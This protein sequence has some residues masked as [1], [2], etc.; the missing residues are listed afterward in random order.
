MTMLAF[1]EYAPDVSPFGEEES[2]V[3]QNVFARKDGYG[4]VMSPSVYSA[5]L[6]SACR[7]YF[8]ARNADA[9]ITVFAAT[10]TK[11]YKLNNTDFTWTDVSKG[12]GSYSGVPNTDQWQF[13]QFN[14]FV[15]AVQ[16][17]TAPQVLDLTSSTAFAD[18]GGSPPQARYIAIVNRFVVLCG[19]GASTPYRIQWSG[20]NA[21]TTWTSGVN[22][23]DFQDLPDGGPLRGVAGGESGLIMQ[24]ASIRRM[25]YAPGSPVIFQIER[26]AQDKGI[27]APLSLVRAGDRVFF[28]GNDGFQSVQPGGYPSF[29]GKERV[30]RTFFADVDLSNLQLM[31]GASDPKTSRVYW[32]YKSLA[33]IA[34][35][36]DKVLVYDFVLDRWTIITGWSGEYIA[37][38]ARPGLTLENLDAIAPSIDQLGFSL[39]DVATGALAQLSIVNASHQLSFL[40][41]AN[42]EATLDTA[43]H[44][45]DGGARVRVRG[46][47]P[48]TD[49]ATCYGA[50]GTRESIQTT[51]TYSAEQ[52]VNGKGL[53]I[54]NVST[55]LARGRIRIPSGTAWTFATG[56]EPA[57]AREGT[58]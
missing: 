22:S 20:L 50:I 42:L 44:E 3:I 6:T 40:S 12:A 51:P 52:A 48:D 8:Y 38:L 16:I 56:V 31:L 47:R 37:S 28:C 4:P 36:F 39:D 41:G 35:A 29:I 32:A 54:A 55:R 30:D 7:G 18:L 57:F 2:Q 58:R 34:G 53:C 24:D 10:A 46:F 27:F 17:N 23:S 9:S 49:A 13:A 19:L 5:A 14:N 33:G 25:I 15:F 1:P 26:L 11:L 21:T 45:A 43:E